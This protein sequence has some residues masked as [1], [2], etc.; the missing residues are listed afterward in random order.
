MNNFYSYTKYFFQALSV[1]IL[2][3][4]N[5]ILGDLEIQSG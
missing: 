5:E 2:P 1:F 3:E 4:I